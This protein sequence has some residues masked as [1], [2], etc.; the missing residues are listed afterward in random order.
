MWTLWTGSCIILL[1]G[2][3]PVSRRIH[4]LHSVRRTNQVS[5]TD[6]STVVRAGGA[7]VPDTCGEDRPLTSVE[8]PGAILRA[9]REAHGLSLRDLSRSTKISPT[10]L[11][12]LEQMRFDRLPARIFTRGFVKAYAREVG[13]DSEEMANR[14]LPGTVPMES[15]MESHVARG[16]VPIERH[17]PRNDAAR[18]L[19]DRHAARYAWLM[20]GVAMV[21]LVGYLWSFARQS[22]EQAPIELSGL[23]ASSDA[24][25][26]D[27]R[28]TSGNDA[29][30]AALDDD[31]PIGPLVIQLNAR[32]PCWLAAA[33]DGT[34][35]F[36]RLFQA[37][38]SQT[39]EAHD[40][41]VLRVGDP[42]T[43]VYS[44]N[45]R[46]GRLLGE[47]GEPINIRITRRNFREFLG[48]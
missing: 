17:V 16:P 31:M 21:G 15:P 32:G 25:P 37:G 14:Y 41:L 6:S 40:E 3:F 8:N 38:Q 22:P 20:T 29:A 26:A 36:A 30:A 39:I 19:V 18:F 12:A 48:T 2:V 34:P 42:G 24:T 1:S 5:L 35:M 7:I 43:L 27:G 11:T 28:A 23:V 4:H 13:L 10:L 47:P 9:A 46:A 45:G 44:V 33:V